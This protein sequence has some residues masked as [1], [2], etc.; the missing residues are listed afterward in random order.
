VKDFTYPSMRAGVISETKPDPVAAPA[1]P[2]G[3]IW[4]GSK[5]SPYCMSPDV[6][7]VGSESFTLS[8]FV[9]CPKSTKKGSGGRIVSRRKGINGFELLVKA[10]EA[11]EV[12][13][14]AKGSGHKIGKTALND[15]KWHAICVV[16]D[17]PAGRV[18][19]YV[20]GKVDGE[21]A[22]WWSGTLDVATPCSVGDWIV[23]GV[24]QPKHFHPGKIYNPLIR[25]GVHRPSVGDKMPTLL[26]SDPVAASSALGGVM[27]GPWMSGEHEAA[28]VHHVTQDLWIFF[29]NS[30][31]H[32]KMV[33]ATP[34][35]ISACIARPDSPVGTAK[36][37]E[38]STKATPEAISAAWDAGL[39][40][41]KGSV[42]KGKYLLKKIT[43]T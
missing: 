24:S 31:A 36:V 32:T 22:A 27:Y 16:Y 13:M 9:W 23:D 14:V 34:A 39:T 18:T 35:D 38:G 28:A 25:T 30:G 41:Y 2:A 37:V 40:N 10:T 7:R 1:A 3:T 26:A 43:G 33:A 17:K 12:W 4:D 20:D 5:D 42:M 21:K 11:F 29:V 6:G 15:E 8:A 19:A